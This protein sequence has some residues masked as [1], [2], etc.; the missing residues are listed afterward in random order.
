MFR[1]FR[2]D[3]KKFQNSFGFKKFG[4]HFQS[5]PDT[6]WSIW[7]YFIIQ[8][9]NNFF[10]EILRFSKYEIVTVFVICTRSMGMCRISFA[11]TRM[12]S[13]TA[14]IQPLSTLWSQVTSIL[15][16]ELIIN[17]LISKKMVR[18]PYYFYRKFEKYQDGRLISKFFIGDPYPA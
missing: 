1:K 14:C 15:V 7:A 16:F 4:R 5:V 8:I 2:S 6:F 3:K 10:L 17:Q 18:N 12:Q 11:S 9:Y 13:K